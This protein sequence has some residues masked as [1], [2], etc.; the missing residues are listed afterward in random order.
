M[1][2]ANYTTIGQVEAEQDDPSNDMETLASPQFAS[3][4]VELTDGWVAG[5]RETVLCELADEDI[6]PTHGSWDRV[7]HSKPREGRENW[8]HRFVQDGQTVAMLVIQRVEAE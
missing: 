2:I 7:E 5:L 3:I 4:A 8:T 6:D 1:F